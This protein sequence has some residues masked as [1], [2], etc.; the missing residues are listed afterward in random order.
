MAP[1]IKRP[2]APSGAQRGWE[3]EGFGDAFNSPNSKTE[4]PHQGAPAVVSRIELRIQYPRLGGNR[5]TFVETGMRFLTER[6]LAIGGLWAFE[7]PKSSAAFHEAA[8][9]VIG[10]LDGAVPS[11][12]SIWP[13]L[14]LGRLQW[15]GKT[16]GLPQLRVDG[17]TDAKVD[18]R[19]AR[20]VLAGVVA[21]VVFD[22]E[23]RP[24]SSLDELVTG[25][26]VIRVA[27]VKMRRDPMQLF[28]KTVA[29]IELALKE[30]I[31][32]VR[33]IATQL[34]GKGSIKTRRLEFLLQPLK[35]TGDQLPRP[36]SA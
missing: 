7:C 14:E 13:V 20:S 19:R 3:T 33:E 9:C 26:A 5:A 36:P 32:I 29:D 1:N 30:H 17:A 35:G 18:L 24:A 8:H 15:I 31:E 6:A 10:A 28:I 11:R 16:Y 34:L 2:V 22:P 12:A 21:E 25:I 23:Y 4:G 27:A